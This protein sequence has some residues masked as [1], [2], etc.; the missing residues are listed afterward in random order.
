MLLKGFGKILINFR[1][2]WQSSSVLD[3]LISYGMVE[4]TWDINMRQI[5]L[6]IESN[7][8]AGKLYK[9]FIERSGYQVIATEDPKKALKLAH[10]W[11]PALVII[12]MNLADN[13][14]AWLIER[15]RITSENTTRVILTFCEEIEKASSLALHADAIIA[16]PFDCWQIATVVNQ[17]LNKTPFSDAKGD[18]STSV[19][20]DVRRVSASSAA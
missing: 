15:V 9:S 1:H 2:S 12:D 19:D 5:V 3:V 17:V 14:S 8:Y 7:V 18:S 13:A 16:K 4:L 20:R 10:A 6:V 11:Q